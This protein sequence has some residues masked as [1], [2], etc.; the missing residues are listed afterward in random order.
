[1]ATAKT[2]DAELLRAH[3][4]RKQNAT[5]LRHFV[6]HLVLIGLLIVMLYPVIWMVFS[7]FRPEREIFGDVSFIPTNWTVDNFVSGWTLFGDKTFL[8]FFINSMVICILSILGNLIACSMA[9]YA[10][11]RLEFKLKWLWF[12][13]MLG[14]IMLPI[15]VQLIP[16]YIFF[17][18]VG[19]VNTI[20][21]LVV[22]K[23]LAHDAFFVFLMVQ[24]MRSLPSE[25]EQAAVVDGASYWQRYWRII[26][27]L[28]MPALVTTAV[29]TF[30]NTYNDFFS[31]LI[32]LTDIDTMTVPV[33]LRLFLDP[34][35]GQSSFGGLFAMVLVSIGPVLGFFLAS[36]RLLTKGI[37]TQ[38]FK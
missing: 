7:A 15:H 2:Y 23:F 20:L 35:G 11:A 18:Q 28:T 36:Q 14:T 5:R 3:R 27:P 24:F 19:W 1:M 16:Q 38:G 6:L 4:Q 9:A 10:F 17:L 34:S 22:P 32:Y 33:A 29:F 13:I 30:I 12:A 8:S 26:L 21:P 25:L 31:Q 37:A